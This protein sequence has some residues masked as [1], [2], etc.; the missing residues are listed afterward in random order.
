MLLSD[1]KC[2]ANILIHFI[3]RIYSLSI[4]STKMFRILSI[5]A[6]IFISFVYCL[7]ICKSLIFILPLLLYLFPQWMQNFPCMLIWSVNEQLH[8]G[9]RF[10]HVQ[11]SNIEWYIRKVRRFEIDTKHC[12]AILHGEHVTM[13]L[14]Q[15]QIHKAET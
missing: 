6:S 11:S 12:F 8:W 5:N 4:R 15:V 3:P 10:Q 14:K 9:I 2:H 7:Q 1:A 13:L